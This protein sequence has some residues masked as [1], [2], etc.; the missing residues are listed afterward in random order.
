MARLMAT[1][2]VNLKDYCETAVAATVAAKR[3][4]GQAR[5]KATACPRF[6]RPA[7]RWITLVARRSVCGGSR[8]C[9]FRSWRAPW[10][11]LDFVPEEKSNIAH[12]S[13]ANTYFHFLWTSA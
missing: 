11:I 13:H 6:R 4:V 10:L 5:K 9:L 3:P 1:R 2:G 7:G 8:A 12:D